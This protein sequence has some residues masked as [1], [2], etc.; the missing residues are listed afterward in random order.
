MSD[1]NEYNR[2]AID[3]AVALLPYW[4][5]KLGLSHWDIRVNIARQAEMSGEYNLAE[6]VRRMSDEVAEIKILDPIDYHPSRTDLYFKYLP[7]DAEHSLV[8]ELLHLLF[9]WGDGSESMDVDLFEVALNRLARV[10]VSY[11]R[12]ESIYK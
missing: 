10:L 3:C 6:V 8:H 2:L 9:G 5:E 4:K 12:S 1:N 7:L 11:R